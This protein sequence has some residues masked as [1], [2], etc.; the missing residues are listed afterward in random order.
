MGN[1]RAAPLLRL[2]AT[3][4]D[5]YA[6][7]MTRA[8]LFDMDGTLIHSDPLHIEVFRAF[9]AERGRAIDTEYFLKHIHGG[10]N[11]EIFGRDFPG[12]DAKALGDEKE[13]LFRARL[14]ERMDPT[15]GTH[16]LLDRAKAEGWP[17]AVVTNAPRLNAEAMLRTLGLADRIETLVIGDEC[18]RSKPDP[19]PYR[20]AMER[21]GIAPHHAIA[22]EDSPSGLRSARS[23]GAK[24][25]GVRSSLPHDRLVE[26]GAHLSVADF[27]DP[28][29]EALLRD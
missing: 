29:I 12:E 6:L 5:R 18:A 24:V 3:T 14:P 16:A 13:A 27:T 2:A 23:A 1:F 7:G 26:A 17:V 21:V 28:Q 9:Y 25:V 22:F 11:A 10:S 4:P 8:L 20:V 15:P 19:T